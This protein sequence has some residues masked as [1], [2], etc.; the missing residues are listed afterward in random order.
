MD[1]KQILEDAYDRIRDRVH[2]VTD[3]LTSSDLAFRPDAE[4]N[5]IGW[6]I[7]HLTRVQ[8]HHVSDIAGRQQEWVEADWPARFGLDPDP[9]NTG[10]AHTSDQVG[11][12]RPESRDLL[13]GYFEAVHQRTLNYLAAITP[14]EL[15]RIIDTSWDP[16]VS[17]GVRLV[18]VIADDLQHVG[19]A[20]YVRGLL[21]RR[22]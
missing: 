7:W 2:R 13:Q 17:V 16:P 8:D 18:S 12:V 14:T 3:G 19:Q 5:S 11:A 1:T 20:A 10:Y 15:D 4:A 21:E 6:L 22:G 9:E